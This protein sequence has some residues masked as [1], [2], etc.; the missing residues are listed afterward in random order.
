M[1]KI[2][3]GEL[4]FNDDYS[5]THHGVLFSGVAYELDEKGRTI[6]EMAFRKG[7]QDGISTTFFPSGAIQI[8]KHL[9]FGALHGESHEWFDN[10]KLKERKLGEFGILIERDSWNEK[11]N[12]VSTY[13]LTEEDKNFK[14]LQILRVAKWEE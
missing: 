1:N 2:N 13:R 7:V 5:Y 3:I 12:L 8:K 9:R 10:G 11:G 4:D 6:A 14:T